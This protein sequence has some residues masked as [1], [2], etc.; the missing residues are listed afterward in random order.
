MEEQLDSQALA[1]WTEKLQRREVHVYLPKFE[2]TTEY[3][4][5]RHLV[6]LGMCSA[7]TKAGA[8]DGADFTGMTASQVAED[9]LY[10]D[11]VLHKANIGVDEEGT[12]AA[13]ATA[14]M[15]IAAGEAFE[16][17]DTDP[18]TP[19]FRADRPFLYLILDV[20]SRCILFLGRLSRPS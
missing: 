7:F 20:Q 11:L 15:M 1:R 4:L 3:D 10:I 12:E 5:N 9:Q 18:F 8:P 16:E 14:L 13:A 2:L 19:V 6:A 17:P